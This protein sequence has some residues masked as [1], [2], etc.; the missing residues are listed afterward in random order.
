MLSYCVRARP[1]GIDWGTR[2][3]W[4]ASRILEERGTRNEQDGNDRRASGGAADR[5]RR[6]WRRRE[7]EHDQLNG[8]HGPDR[9]DRGHGWLGLQDRASGQ[10]AG[11]FGD[12]EAQ[13]DDA[14]L[15]VEAQDSG[16]LTQ[17]AGL[18]K[19]IEAEAGAVV[20]GSGAGDA[21]V[22]QFASA[23]DAEEVAK[24]NDV[25]PLQ[26]EIVDGTIVVLATK[27]NDDLLNEITSAIGG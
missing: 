26:A 25:A 2:A 1:R 9:R 7:R 27:D 5:R 19:P 23:S 13:L 4:P 18:D 22:Q 3:A 16:A 11:A 21:V 15:D 8:R 17:N 10:T 12:V 24:A 6:L 14:G 20:T